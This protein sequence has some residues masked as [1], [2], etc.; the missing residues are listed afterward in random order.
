MGI[1]TETGRRREEEGEEMT[2]RQRGEFGTT[3]PQR[4]R[5]SFFPWLFGFFG[6]AFFRFC[7]LVSIFI[8]SL[9]RDLSGKKGGLNC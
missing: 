7:G 6:F 3:V 9:L 2:W 4:I 5:L 8:F 1:Q